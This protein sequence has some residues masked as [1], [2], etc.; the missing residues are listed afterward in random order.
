MIAHMEF[1]GET[2]E[3]ALAGKQMQP[4]IQGPCPK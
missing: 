1:L 4:V 2:I 3:H